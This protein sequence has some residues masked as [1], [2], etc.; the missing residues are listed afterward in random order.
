MDQRTELSRH[1]HL[2]ATFTLTNTNNN[3]NQ[4]VVQNDDGDDDDVDDWEWTLYRPWWVRVIC[5][6][7]GR[8]FGGGCVM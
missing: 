4:I 7:A 6:V 3:T 1:F 8:A 2:L 5:V